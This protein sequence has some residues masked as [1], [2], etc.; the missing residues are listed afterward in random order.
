MVAAKAKVPAEVDKVPS[1]D[2]K[3]LTLTV[4]YVPNGDG[5]TVKRELNFLPLSQVP[6]G[7]LRRTRRDPTEQMWLT[8][9]WALAP[10]DLDILDQVSSDKLDALL[11]EMQ[12]LSGT[13][14]GES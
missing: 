13:R 14:S 12:K 1:E 9:E 5:T 6:L 2:A 11:I 3:R 8:L 4:E 7:I 10:E